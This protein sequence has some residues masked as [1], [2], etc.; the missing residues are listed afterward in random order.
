MIHIDA[1]KISEADPEILKVIREE[2]NKRFYMSFAD[3]LLK[4]N[5]I[6]KDECKKFKDKYYE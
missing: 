3:Y 5:Y 4:N 6:T 1:D 2:F